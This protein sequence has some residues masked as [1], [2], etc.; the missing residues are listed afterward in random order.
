MERSGMG[1]WHAKE[2]GTSSFP[3]P[4][5]DSLTQNLRNQLN[6]S[7]NSYVYSLKKYNEFSIAFKRTW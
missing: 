6:K 7:G 1:T 5:A 2:N 4:G 3:S